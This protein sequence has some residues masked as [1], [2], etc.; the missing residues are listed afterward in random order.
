MATRLGLL[1]IAGLWLAAPPGARAGDEF[2]DGFKDELGRLA[3]HEAVGVGRRVLAQVLLVG[4]PAYG[5]GYYSDYPTH[6][7]SYRA[8][9]YYHEY[10]GYGYR[11][12]S[13]GHGW[14]HHRH[15]GHRWHRG[16][17]GH[18]YWGGGGHRHHRHR[19]HHGCRH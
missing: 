8:Y 18:K 19:H 17:Y 1:A 15:H 9:G 7:P 2:E 4:D 6:R 5:Y 11:R 13:W 10:D 3:A 12:P 14:G 16:G